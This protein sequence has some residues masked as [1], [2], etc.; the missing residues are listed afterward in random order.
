MRPTCSIDGRRT[1]VRNNRIEWIQLTK[2]NRPMAPLALN[3]SANEWLGDV[4]LAHPGLRESDLLVAHP[5]RFERVAFA[6][7][8]RRSIQLSYGCLRCLRSAYAE[9]SWL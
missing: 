4:Q 2:R 6:F 3:A 1:E 9:T 8:G 7:G 5:T